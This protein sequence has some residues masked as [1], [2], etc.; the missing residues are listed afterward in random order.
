MIKVERKEDMSAELIYCWVSQCFSVLVPKKR[1]GGFLKVPYG[2]HHNAELTG[3]ANK[4]GVDVFGL[5]GSLDFEVNR[6]I[7]YGDRNKFSSVLMPMLESYYG[8]PSREVNVNDFWR[9]H[10]LNSV[11]LR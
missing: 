5:D 6:S 7:Y 2:H 3:I 11:L 10:P 8:L 4:I 1:G 9:L